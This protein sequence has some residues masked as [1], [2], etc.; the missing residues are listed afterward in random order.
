M[1]RYSS[2]VNAAIIGSI[3]GVIISV[4][5]VSGTLAFF[6]YQKE[7]EQAVSGRYERSAILSE[8]AMDL[9]PEMTLVRS[10]V[11]PMQN[12]SVLPE[13]YLRNIGSLTSRE[14]CFNNFSEICQEEAYLY[15]NAEREIFGLK[16]VD[17]DVLERYL[18][19]Q[20]KALNEFSENP[21]LFFEQ[22]IYG[23]QE[24]GNTDEGVEVIFNSVLAEPPVVIVEEVIKSTV[25]IEEVEGENRDN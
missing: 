23:R 7:T 18:E 24:A 25:I 10:I 6:A 11:I 5:G 22:Y 8:M 2:E 21:Q 19:P 4:I 17:Q 15:I 14:L 13:R 1:V 12:A 9:S 16:P 3:A 20:F